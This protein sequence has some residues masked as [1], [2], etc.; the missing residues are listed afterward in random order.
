MLMNVCT[1]IFAELS[2][3]FFERASAKKIFHVLK[4]ARQHRLHQFVF[5]HIIMN[6]YSFSIKNI[7]HGT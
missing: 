6:V 7:K 2:K 1:E 4:T 5:L 3:F